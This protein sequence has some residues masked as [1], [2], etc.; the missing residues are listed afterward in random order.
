MSSHEASDAS[1]TIDAVGRFVDANE[2]ALELLGVSLP[3][4]LASPP[5]RFTIRPPVEVDQSASHG[6]WATGGSQPRVGTA[7]LRR[8]DGT[9]RVAYAIEPAGSGYRARLWPAED[10][11]PT[12]TS[13]LTVG[14]V[15]REWRSA[16]RELAGLVPGTPEWLR[17]LSEI[18]A[19]RGRYQEV[20][21]AVEPPAG[22]P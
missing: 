21:K 22:D 18:E 5:E 12:A 2:A 13:G 7:G 9:I 20:F 17:R 4:L 3:E 8:G 10:A 16:E 11:P 14:G 19:L 6:E 1:I 15:L